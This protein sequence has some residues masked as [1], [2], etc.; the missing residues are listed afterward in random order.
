MAV[1]IKPSGLEMEV[2]DRKETIKYVKSL[3]WTRKGDGLSLEDMTKG[4]LGKYAKDR[5]DIDLDQ[6]KRKDDLIIKVKAL[7]DDNGN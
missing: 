3:G 1:W 5:F 4:Q 2:N 7:E 6:G